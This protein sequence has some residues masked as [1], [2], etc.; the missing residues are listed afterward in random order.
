[1]ADL[2]PIAT[3]GRRWRFTRFNAGA[4]RRVSI[5][6][7][8]LAARV[9]D[10]R[11]R[12][13]ASAAPASVAAPKLRARGVRP[14]PAPSPARRR[15]APSSRVRGRRARPMPIVASAPTFATSPGSARISSVSISPAPRTSSGCA[16]I[17][18]GAAAERA[19][20]RAERAEHGG[21]AAEREA[22][23]AHAAA[24]AGLLRRRARQLGDRR[25]VRL[26]QR[27]RRLQVAGG[28]PAL[29]ARTARGRARGCRSTCG[30]AV[31]RS[32]PGPHRRADSVQAGGGQQLRRQR[33]VL[34]RRDM[35]RAGQCEV[36]VVE[37][38]PLQHARRHRRRRLERLRGGAQE[39]GQ[40]GRAVRRRRHRAAVPRRHTTA[41]SCTDS[42]RPPRSTCTSH[43]RPSSARERT[44]ARRGPRRSTLMPC[45][46][47]PSWRRSSRPSHRRFT[48]SPIARTP[49]AHFAVLKTGAAAARRTHRPHASRTSGGA[50]STCCSRPAT[51][52][53]PCT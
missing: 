30:R 37:A 14:P 6:P 52:R 5:A 11:R 40:L 26:L 39:H 4:L 12:A 15:P 32:S 34:R 36:P 1:M 3:L 2:V 45:R 42:T 38:E 25:A 18:L 33:D 10:R 22:V 29:A 13:G 17:A 53:W 41:T 46:S 49:R 19:V 47:Y 8:D 51:S 20:G 35:R 50:A 24:V 23:G 31:R 28:R 27:M 16:R 48:A 21:V 43:V 44:L 9:D 7:D